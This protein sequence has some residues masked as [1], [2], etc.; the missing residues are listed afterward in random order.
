M[1]GLKGCTFCSIK[2]SVVHLI[3]KSTFPEFPAS[4]SCS[5]LVAGQCLPELCL[6]FLED[7]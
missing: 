7:E 6:Q 4:P 5:N 3:A 2:M 1:L